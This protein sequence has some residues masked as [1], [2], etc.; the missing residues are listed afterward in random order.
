MKTLKFLLLVATI[1]TM[2]ACSSDDDGGG[3][4]A[5]TELT[6]A[7]IA[8]TYAITYYAGRSETSATAQ[9]STVVIQTE[10]YSGDTFTN[11]IAT[12]NADGT[13]VLSGDYRETYTITVTGQAPVTETEIIPLDDAG[14]F[15]VNN[16]SRTITLDGDVLEVLFFNGTNLNIMGSDSETDQGFTYTDEF[17]YRLEKM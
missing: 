6:T 3:A 4:P 12:F 7:N 14:T 11:A 5:Q 13:Y 16:T 17:E 2:S 1:F 15:S 9:G 10:E 8:G